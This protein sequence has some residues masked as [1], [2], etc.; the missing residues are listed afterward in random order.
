M[1][2]EKRE[3]KGEERYWENKDKSDYYK[4]M[5]W[6]DT[7]T[8]GTPERTGWDRAKSSDKNT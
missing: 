6:D 2:K 5:P 3:E 4:S 1:S 7:P 8:Q